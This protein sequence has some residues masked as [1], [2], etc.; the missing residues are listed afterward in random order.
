MP[1]EERSSA[2]TLRGNSF[3]VLG[4]ELRPGDTAPNFSLVG[5]GNSTV[6]LQ[7]SAGK[8]RLIS[9][10]PSLDTPVCSTETQK[11]EAKRPS[12]GDVE[13]ITISMDL[14][15]A[16]ARWS[17]EHGVQHAVLSAHK[18]EQFGIDYGVLIKELRL[19][20][21]S[22]FVVDSDDKVRYVEYVQEIPFEP[23]YDEAMQA[24]KAIGGS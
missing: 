3:T 24:L 11:W 17:G 22:V 9:C 8:V 12:L 2:A 6:S 20:Q 23:D 16:Q 15:P 13:L 21:R 19:L 5:A 14:P 1:V 4:R 7:D 18:N 10:V